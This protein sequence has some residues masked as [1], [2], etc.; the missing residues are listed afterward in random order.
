M[1]CFDH[2]RLERVGFPETSIA[3]GRSLIEIDECRGVRALV[4]I[5]HIAFKLGEAMTF[6]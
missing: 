3:V 6:E 4:P 1:K 2:G 5:E